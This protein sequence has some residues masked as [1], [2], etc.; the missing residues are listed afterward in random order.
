MPCLLIFI[1]C[2]PL[3]SLRASFRPLCVL[4]SSFGCLIGA[5]LISQ[6]SC[7]QV[8]SKSGAS[9]TDHKT[10]LVPL[11]CADIFFP[12]DFSLLARAYAIDAVGAPPPPPAVQ[13]PLAPAPAS[14]APTGCCE[15]MFQRDFL[16]RFSRDPR[17]TETRNGDNPMLD[18]ALRTRVLN[19]CVP[20]SLTFPH[21]PAHRLQQHERLN[22][23]ARTRQAW[24]AC[25]STS[26]IV[27]AG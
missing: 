25:A 13:E 17:R 8:A 27:A 23:S 3:T 4:R 16:M 22:Y 18:G 14:N 1:H 15:T 21:L 20:T 5:V 26:V 10:Y 2:R 9:D 11:G 24:R 6:L 12:T 19:I 7:S